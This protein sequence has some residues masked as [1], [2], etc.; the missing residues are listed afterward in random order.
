MTESQDSA[1]RGTAEAGENG[2]GKGNAQTLPDDAARCQE[3]RCNPLSS[4]RG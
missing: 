2:T 4:F 3:A 1:S